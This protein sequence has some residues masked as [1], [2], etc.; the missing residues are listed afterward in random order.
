MFVHLHVIV[1]ITSLFSPKVNRR[2]N[3]KEKGT[4]LI[5]IIVRIYFLSILQFI[6]GGDSDRSLTNKVNSAVGYY[7]NFSYLVLV[8]QHL[9]TKQWIF[10]PMSRLSEF[11]I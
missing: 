1:W 3:G 11:F 9:L 7:A 4:R 5:L 10:S 8:T 6:H 2:R